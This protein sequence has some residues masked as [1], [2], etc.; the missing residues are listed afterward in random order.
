VLAA[1]RTAVITATA[2]QSHGQ[3]VPAPLG[4]GGSARPGA[5]PI[6]Q[7]AN[8]LA[9]LGVLVSNTREPEGELMSG[10]SS[11]T[12]VAAVRALLNEDA[13]GLAVLLPN[14]LPESGREQAQREPRHSRA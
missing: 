9:V 6:A 12:A 13:E 14:G 10:E 7:I 3:M 11:L 2:A 5:G 4:G 8:P 1:F